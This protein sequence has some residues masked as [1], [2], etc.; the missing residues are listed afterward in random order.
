MERVDESHLVDISNA[1]V[2]GECWFYVAYDGEDP[3]N[4]NRVPT[5]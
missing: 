3:N 2:V 4:P 1:Q 5:W